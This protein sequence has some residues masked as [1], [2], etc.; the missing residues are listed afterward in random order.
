MKDEEKNRKAKS[1]KWYS[2]HSSFTLKSHVIKY[3]KEDWH[4]EEEPL[5]VVF[6]EKGTVVRSNAYHTA[7]IWGSAAYPFDI[8]HE[9]TLWKKPKWN[10]EFLIEGVVTSCD[11]TQLVRLSTLK[12][13]FTKPHIVYAT[14]KILAFWDVEAEF[15]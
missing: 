7:M 2:L 6:N 15:L 4:F 13:K 12:I 14:P 3:I 11:K 9:I 5:L 8:Q 1:T 10:L